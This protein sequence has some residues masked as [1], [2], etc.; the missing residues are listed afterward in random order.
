MKL[1]E[2]SQHRKG[3]TII[4]LLIVISVIGIMSALVISSFSGAAQDTRRV[5]A[6]QQ[7]AAI[8]SAVNAWVTST[9]TTAGLSGALTTYNAAGSSLAR[10]NLVSMYLDDSTVAHFSLN[11]TVG[12][13]VKSVAL[14]KLGQQIDLPSWQ[15]S[16]YPK[17]ELVDSP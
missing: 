7:Q 4:E 2:Q 11:S 3:F 8:Q 5:I 1:P 6:R 14:Q 17:V 16:S 12:G 9:S 15:S 13:A 10:F